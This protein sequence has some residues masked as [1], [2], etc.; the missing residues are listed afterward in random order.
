MDLDEAL[1]LAARCGAA[2]LTGRGP[3]EG[4]LTSATEPLARRRR[5]QWSAT[6]PPSG[7]SGSPFS[8]QASSPPAMLCAS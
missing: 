5:L 1:E 2:C 8:T 7:S 6:D 4:Q 3:Y